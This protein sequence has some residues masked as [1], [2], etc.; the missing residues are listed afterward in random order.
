M[1]HLIGPPR[2]ED[3]TSPRSLASNIRN[4]IGSAVA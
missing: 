2:R 3:F 4:L 1:S